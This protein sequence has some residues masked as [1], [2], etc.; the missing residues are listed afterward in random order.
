MPPAGLGGFIFDTSPPPGSNDETV[1]VPVFAGNPTQTEE[2]M[3][4]TT[5]SSSYHPPDTAVQNTPVPPV[6]PS[7][8]S[9]DEM[10]FSLEDEDEDDGEDIVIADDL[11]ENLD[12]E[13]DHGGKKKDKDTTPPA[14]NG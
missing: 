4:N 11:A 3:V 6:P 14:A 13:T 10:D 12:G 8:E 5:T 2:M 9:L 1:D 7:A